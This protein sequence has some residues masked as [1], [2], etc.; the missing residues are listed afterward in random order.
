MSKEGEK[1]A[2]VGL[3]CHIHGLRKA[4]QVNEKLSEE[5]DIRLSHRNHHRTCHIG[6]IYNV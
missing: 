2:V 6:Y 4:Q 5:V 1:F 3:P